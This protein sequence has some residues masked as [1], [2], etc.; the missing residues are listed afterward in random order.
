[1]TDAARI[2]ALPQAR[3]ETHG[4]SDSLAGGPADGQAC[5]RHLS[6]G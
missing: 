5:A 2:G 4:V 6:A 1:M 3:G